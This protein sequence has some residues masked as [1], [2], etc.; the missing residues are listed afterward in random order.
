MATPTLTRHTLPGVL[1]PI[2]VDIR[3]S[4]RSAARPAVLILPGFKG[5]KEW[6]MFPALAERVARAGFSAVSINVSGAG[7]DDHGRFVFPGRFGHNTFSA[8]LEDVRRVLDAL[9][10]GHLGMVPTSSVGLVGHSRGG[11][12]A[13][14]TAA[15]DPRVHALVTWAAIS[16]VDRWP[17]KAAEWRAAGKLDITNARTGDILPLYVDV[18]DDV[19]ANRETLDIAAAA[20]RLT[21]PWLLLHGAADPSVPLAESRVLSGAASPANPPRLIIIDGAGHTLG[22]VHPFAGMTPALAQA[23]D[24]TV[25]WLGRYL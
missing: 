12:M 4:D 20:G 13:I 18:L 8:E 23:L 16:T 15:R 2:A 5:F 19:L 10:H 9:E 24:E 1:G 11:G 17:D 6:G 7:V 14:L 25:K 21:I 22:A 3:T